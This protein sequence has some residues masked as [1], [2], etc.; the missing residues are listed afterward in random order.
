MTSFVPFSELEKDYSM[1]ETQ[2][3]EKCYFFPNNFKLCAVKN[4]NFISII[5]NCNKSGQSCALLNY[6]FKA[7]VSTDQKLLIAK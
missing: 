6:F 4:D 3:L 5:E 7:F 2:C 1:I